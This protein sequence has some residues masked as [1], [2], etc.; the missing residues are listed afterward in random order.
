M[1][2]RAGGRGLRHRAL[3][4]RAGTEHPDRRQQRQRA[5]YPLPQ[6]STSQETTKPRALG[7]SHSVLIAAMVTPMREIR[8]RKDYRAIRD[9]RCTSLCSLSHSARAHA[10]VQT[11]MLRQQFHIPCYFHLNTCT[12]TRCPATWPLCLS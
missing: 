5:T 9:K 8:N 12:D 4:C 3:C 1:G 7:V 2:L 6:H 11:C 10:S